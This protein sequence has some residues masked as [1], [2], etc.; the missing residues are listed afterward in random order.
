MEL[1]AIVCLPRRPLCSICPVKESVRHPRRSQA[2]PGN[3][4]PRRRRDI[5]YALD[6]HNGSIFLVQRPKHASLMPGMWELPEIPVATARTSPVNLTVRHSITVT[7][8]TVHVLRGPAPVDGGRWVPKT[9]VQSCLSPVWHEKSCGGRR[10]SKMEG[11]MPKWFHIFGGRTMAA[12]SPGTPAPDFTL[13][14]M[15]GKQFSLRDALARGP[16]V[17]AFFKISCPTCQYTFPFC[18]GSTRH[19]ETRPSLS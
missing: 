16:V 15:D 6:H 12:L 3:M 10:S 18:N 8:Y 7:D 14:A 2:D 9:R 17:A 5:C 11:L 13:R 1:G 19:T 4:T